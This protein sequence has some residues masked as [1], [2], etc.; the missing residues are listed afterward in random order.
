[1]LNCCSKCTFC[2]AMNFL[3]LKQSEKGR[4]GLCERITITCN[5]CNKDIKTFETSPKL[6]NT[7]RR[8]R[9]RDINL[10]SVYAATSVG[11]GLAVLRS[12]CTAMDLPSPIYPSNYSTYLKYITRCAEKNCEESMKGA[13]SSLHKLHKVDDNIVIGIPV[14]VDGTWQKRYGHN[15]LLGVSFLVFIDN[16]RVLDYSIKSKS[17][18]VCESNQNA[19]SEWKGRHKDVCA[20][21]HHSSSGAMERDGDVSSFA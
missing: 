1:M 20:I 9:M 16:G 8:T 12:F 18:H 13:A 7:V 6:R 2:E 10:R 21:N 15:A 5:S 11:G 3:P 19:S 4:K 14:S 17:C